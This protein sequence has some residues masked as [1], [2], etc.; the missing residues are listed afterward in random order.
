MPQS[1]PHLAQ[2]VLRPATSITCPPQPTQQQP[3]RRRQIP[4]KELF[5][6]P[7]NGD[8]VATT[9]FEFY[10]KAGIQNLEAEL[11]AYDTSNEEEM[12]V[13]DQDV[14]MDDGTTS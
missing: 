1:G 5:D 3:R 9:R 8:T 2:H 10:W 4:L 11:A 7:A 6:Y 14:E 12:M 13:T